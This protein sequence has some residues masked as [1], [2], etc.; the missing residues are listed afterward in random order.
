MPAGVHSVELRGDEPAE[1]L[2][3]AEDA[4]L[5]AVAERRRRDFTAGRHCARRALAALGREPEP[6]LSGAHR[7]PRWPAG[8]LG[9]ITHCEGYAAAAVARRGAIVALGIDAEPHDVL[10]AGVLGMIACDEERAWIAAADPGTCWDRLLFSAKESVFK[11]WFPLARR[12]L[13]FTD[14]V[15]DIDPRNGGFAAR[16]LVAAPDVDRR[17]LPRLE[18]RFAI[19]DGVVLTA[20]VLSRR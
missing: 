13:D 11:A 5:G 3:P 15:V 2:L 8:V 14:A 19:R 4:A 6:I 1:R 10:P 20:V 17:P 7:E 18:G 12:L 9:S 16:L